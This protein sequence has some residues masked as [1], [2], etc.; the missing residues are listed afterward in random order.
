MQLYKNKTS[1]YK[2]SSAES[3]SGPT[4]PETKAPTTQH[5]RKP[6]DEDSSGGT[7]QEGVGEGEED[8]DDIVVF[9]ESETGR[10][11]G[12]DEDDGAEK[13]AREKVVDGKQYKVDYF[14]VMS[15]LSSQWETTNHQ[16]LGELWL[17]LLM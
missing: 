13:D 5:S 15:E 16:S 10:A 8:D 6:G 14:S 7:D 1:K 12:D 17:R 2:K 9:K 4:S 11:A 3:G